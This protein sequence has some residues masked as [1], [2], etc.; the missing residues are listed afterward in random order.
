MFKQVMTGIALTLSVSAVA[1]D[2]DITGTVD[3]KC[4]VTTDTIGIYGNP[5][6]SV[7]STD[8]V[9]GGVEPIV[10]YDVIQAN[11]YKAMITTPDQFVES[12]ALDDVVNWTGSV[13]VAE[14]TDP[15][16]S[17]YDNEK[18]L[19]NNVTEVDLTVAGSTWFK[20]SSEA[21][22]GY[23]KAWPAGVYRATVTAECIAL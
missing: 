22:Y 14:V 7:L 12:P 15:T 6:P 2:V 18:R 13:D 10:R 1:A 4:V 3:S 8:A 16:M 23:D 9:S 20:V 17:A 11:Y 19:Y 21:N 5:S